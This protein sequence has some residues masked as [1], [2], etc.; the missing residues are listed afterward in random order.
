[1][2]LGIFIQI[3]FLG[4]LTKNARIMCLKVYPQR[5]FPLMDYT[6]TLLQFGYELEKFN[7]L[8]IALFLGYN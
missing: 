6:P 4:F 3:L 7:S 1:M 2:I 8:F 5:L